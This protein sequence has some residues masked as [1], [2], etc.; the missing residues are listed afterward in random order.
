M[1]ARLRGALV[2]PLRPV[3]HRVQI[4]IDNAVRAAEDR[5][6]RRL[7]E[8]VA[9]WGDAQADGAARAAE[10][11]GRLDEQ[12]RLHELRLAEVSGRLDELDD[13]V[14]RI[15][16]QLVA[17]EHRVGDLE[18]PGVDLVVDDADLGVARSLVDEVRREHGR[19]QAALA[20]IAFYEERIARLEKAADPAAG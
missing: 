4:R 11:S 17:L 2:V 20:A 13:Q 3:M 7:D 9:R 15:S 6:T 19:T 18:R 5:G 8:A 14:R 10:V 1:I 16:A 12:H